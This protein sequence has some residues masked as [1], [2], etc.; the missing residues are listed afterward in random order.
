MGTRTMPTPFTRA[1]GTGAPGPVKSTRRLPRFGVDILPVR[2]S[3]PPDGEEFRWHNY[4]PI[5]AIGANAIVVSFIIP[6]GRN[7][8][9]NW[10]AN[11]YVGG[12]F[13]PG[14][15]LITWQLYRDAT[16]FSTGKGKVMPN[17]D[18]IL[19]S[20][21]VVQAPCRLNGL[22]ASEQQ[23]VALIVFNN[24][25]IPANQQI[26]GLIGG[27]YYPTDLAPATFAF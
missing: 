5:P 20:L 27:Y 26:G 2:N 10:F 13:Q 14:Q 4:V 16:G 25:V 15:G 21:G 18:N 6:Q 9:I 7:V 3:I 19:A 24:G 11:E 12:G 17:F 8:V 1:P 23:K 22:L